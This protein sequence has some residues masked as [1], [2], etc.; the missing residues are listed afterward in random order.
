MKK[1]KASIVV[2]IAL[3]I[4]FAL[5]AC[6]GNGALPQEID[7][8]NGGAVTIEHVLNN[9][10]SYLGDIITLTGIVGSVSPREFVLQ[11]EAATLEITIDYRGNQALPQTGDEVTAIGRFTENRPCCGPGFTLTSLRFDMVE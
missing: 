6:S 8:L 3:V 5:S 10:G 1:A 7:S 11:N 2:C 4:V 9:P